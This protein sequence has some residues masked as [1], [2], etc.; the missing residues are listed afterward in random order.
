MS[1]QHVITYF[2]FSLS[3][4]ALYSLHNVMAPAKKT[5]PAAADDADLTTMSRRDLQALAKSLGVKANGKTAEII[6]EIQAKQVRGGGVS[7]ATTT[8]CSWHG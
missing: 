3:S 8:R 2:T 5:T 6:V 1:F 7:V 4:P